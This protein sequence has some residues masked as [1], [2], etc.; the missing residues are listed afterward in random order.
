MI[1]IIVL[2]AVIFTER[3]NQ[4][5]SV[6]NVTKFFIKDCTAV[7]N[8]TNRTV[9]ASHRQKIWL[10]F[11]GKY[12]VN[13]ILSNQL[14]NENEVIIRATNGRFVI[15]VP[16]DKKMGVAIINPITGEVISMMGK[17]FFKMVFIVMDF[18]SLTKVADYD[19]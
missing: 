18:L 9:L 4:M 16:V 14:T 8:N 2:T 1:K 5:Y 12:F 15:G 10:R 17:R 7:T 13:R 3:I 19:L 11:T 6:R